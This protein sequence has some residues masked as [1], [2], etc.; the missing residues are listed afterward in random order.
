MLEHIRQE[1]AWL[2]IW[3]FWMVAVNLGSLFFLKH[4]EARWA[5]GAFVG[6]AILMETLLAWNGYNRLLGLAHLVFWTPLV[7]WLWRRRPRWPDGLAG[8]WVAL[9]LLTNTASLVVD[10][11][12]VIR[13]LAGDR[14]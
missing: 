2:Q 9:L 10:F 8:K 3:V 5:L 14:S 6:A 13:Y 1:P 12:D 4:R 7:I 11:V